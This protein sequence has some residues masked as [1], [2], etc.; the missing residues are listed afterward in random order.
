MLSQEQA[1]LFELIQNLR[2]DD[3]HRV[4]EYVRKMEAC[5]AVDYSDDWTEEEL[6][7]V[8]NESLRR[9][10]EIDPYDWSDADQQPR[11]EAKE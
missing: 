8:A 6:R 7:A 5:P 10:D 3:V 11:A 1:E 4:L 2:P 9:L